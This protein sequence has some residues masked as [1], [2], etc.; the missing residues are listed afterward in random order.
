MASEFRRGFTALLPV[1]ASVAVYGSVLGVLAAQKGLDWLDILY[2]DLAVFAGS[3]QFVMVEMWGERLP[4]LE[5]AAAVLVIN[6]RYLLVGA[7]LAPLFQGQPLWRKL[8][9]IHLVADENWAVTMAEMRRG[10]GTVMFL[11]GGG[12][13]LIGIW[14]L[15]T[16]VGVLG[17][18]LIA[19]PEEYALDFAFTAVFTALTVGLWRGKRDCLPWLVAAVLAVLAERWLPGKWYIVIGGIGGAIA[20]MLQPESTQEAAH[21]TSR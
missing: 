20:A 13:C 16:V 12:V 3:A 6:L 14:T 5:M 10:R 18:S 21:A 2:M 7:S 19:H 9:V 11:L 1:A 8:G 4:V 17:G 15:G